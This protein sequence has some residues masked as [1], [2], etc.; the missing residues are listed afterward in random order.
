MDLVMHATGKKKAGKMKVSEAVF[1]QTFNEPLVHQVLV[2]FTAGGRSGTKAQKS[3]GDVRGG[4]K[5]PWKQ[6]GTG[7]ARVGS[8][9]SPLWRGG[10]VTF[11][12]RPRDY[13][14]KVNR[15]MYRGALRSILSELVRQERLLCVADF[16]VEEPRTKAA[17]ALLA[18]LGVTE[19]LIIADEITDN[20]RLAIRNLPNVTIIKPSEIDP[21]SL[22]GF[23]HVLMTRTAVEKVEAWLS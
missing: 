8:I 19:A 21:Y 17:A 5:K 4:G 20:A 1:G 7:R 22:V 14:Q 15:K 9:R 10:G 23:E 13:S 18:G 3:R 11:A 12:A 2:A 6:K 16:N